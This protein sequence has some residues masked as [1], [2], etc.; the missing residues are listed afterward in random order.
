MEYNVV[1]PYC[2]DIDQ[3]GCSR[4][5]YKQKYVTLLPLVILTF[6]CQLVMSCFSVIFQGTPKWIMVNML[7]SYKMWDIKNSNLFF[8]LNEIR[9]LTSVYKGWVLFKVAVNGL[10]LSGSRGRSA[11]LLRS[12]WRTSSTVDIHDFSIVIWTPDEWTG[13]EN[14][15]HKSAC[16]YFENL[17]SASTNIS[18]ER[19]QLSFWYE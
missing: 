19:E 16:D 9:N 8:F 3:C 10:L 17:S 4:V 7:S 2:V 15:I 18:D 13:I 12:H 14:L 1:V 5:K 6:R 11:R